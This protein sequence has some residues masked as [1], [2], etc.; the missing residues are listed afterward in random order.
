M[1]ANRGHGPVTTRL[2]DKDR[3]RR[4]IGHNTIGR[5]HLDAAQMRMHGEVGRGVDFTDKTVADSFASMTRDELLKRLSDADIAFAE[6]NNMTDLAIHPHLRRIEV[7][8]PNG[9]VSYPA[10]APIIVGE[11]RAYGAVP[12]IGERPGLSKK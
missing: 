11:T 8:T 7:D 12:G 1:F 3:A 10:P 2:A 5:I 4:R 6:V 9:R